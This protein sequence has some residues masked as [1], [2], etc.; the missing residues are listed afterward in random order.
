[1]HTILQDFLGPITQNNQVDMLINGMEL[2]TGELAEKMERFL[3]ERISTIPVDHLNRNL[4]QIRRVV[5]NHRNMQASSSQRVIVED[6][7]VDDSDVDEETQAQ[8]PVTARSQTIP[9]NNTRPVSKTVRKTTKNPPKRILPPPKRARN[10][11][12]TSS[13]NSNSNNSRYTLR[14]SG[15]TSGE[16]DDSIE[17]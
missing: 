3:R 12:Q 16:Q 7:D 13:N 4:E 11:P 8:V 14:R 2:V 15:N 10:V 17:L 6:S 5:A 1:M 9:R